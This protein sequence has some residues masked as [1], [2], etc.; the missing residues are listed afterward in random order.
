MLSRLSDLIVCASV[1]HL[2]SLPKRSFAPGKSRPAA[3]RL[4]AYGADHVQ[5][6]VFMQALRDELGS[7][8]QHVPSA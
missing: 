5:A 1:S 6:G 3:A 4:E 8:M 7:W 2:G